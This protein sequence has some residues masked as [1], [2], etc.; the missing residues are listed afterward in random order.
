MGLAVALLS[1]GAGVNAQSDGLS[2]KDQKELR[3]VVLKLESV[4]KLIKTLQ[5]YVNLLRTDA[6]LR[7][8]MK[9]AGDDDEGGFSIDG[10]AAASVQAG[11]V[12]LVDG[13]GNSASERMERETGFEPATS[14]LARLHSTS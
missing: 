12:L 9:E 14:T 4:T 13:R 1:A 5:A 8:L 7:V 11:A 2:E 10:R 6:A 3:G